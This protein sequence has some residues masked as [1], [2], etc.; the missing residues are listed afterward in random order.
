[1]LQAMLLTENFWNGNGGEGKQ[2][3]RKDMGR[4]EQKPGERIAAEKGRGGS[5]GRG[6]AKRAGLLGLVLAW[7]RTVSL[8]S[9]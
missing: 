7:V 2:K 6:V 1:M 4:N 5:R 3:W 8:C 9:V